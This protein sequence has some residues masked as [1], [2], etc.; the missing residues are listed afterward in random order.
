LIIGT[1]GHID[2]GKTSLVKALTGVDTDRLKEEKARGITI[3]LGFAYAPLP[4]GGT[5]AFV[6]VPGHEKLIRNMLAGATG[7]DGVL[8]VVAAD[9][10]P[11]PQTREHL[12]IL[13]LLG[14]DRG[15]V[16][17]TKADLVEPARVDAVAA[18]MRTL[19]DGTALAAAPLVPVSSVTGAGI[20]ELRHRLQQAATAAPRRESQGRF[21]LAVDRCFTL[22]GHGTVVTGTAAAGRV[23]V[24]DR[25]VV[26]PRGLAVRVR[27]LHAGNRAAEHGGAGERCALNLAGTGLQKSDVERG[28]W[29]VAEPAHA[30]TDRL[31]ARLLLLGGEAKPLVHWTPLRLHL[32]AAEVGARVVPLQ[33]AGVAPGAAALVQLELDRPIGAL[34]GD[35]FI[36]RDQSA[37]RTLGGGRVIDPFAAARGR[38]RPQRLAQLQA[39]EAPTAAESL[40]A[41]LALAPVD[42]VDLTAFATL[43][44]LDDAERAALLQAVPHTALGDGATQLAFAPAQLERFSAALVAALNQHHRKAPD[45]PGLMLEPLRRSIELK[46]RADVFALLLQHAVGAGRVTRHGPYLSLPGHEVSLLAAEQKLWERV[47]PWLLEAGMHPPRLSDLAARDRSIKPDQLQRLLR[48]L[49]R[50]GRLYAVGNDY[51]VLPQHMRQ[52][53]QQSKALAEADPQR[54]LNVKAL[55]ETTGMSRHLSVPLVEF[56]DHIGFT[57]RAKDGRHVKRD[58][59]AVFG[60]GGAGGTA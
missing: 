47:H 14:L 6:D 50:M 12:A 21:R 56:F 8:L 46:P 59:A 34:R 37:Q 49:A 7:I 15:V 9:D 41:L 26:S 28:D 16:A 31:D 18:Q 30:P 27:G 24:G 20:D 54:R 42:G 60:A 53:A 40:A 5:L 51:Y 33:G 43:W 19:L 13:D 1:A 3:D 58:V 23:A 25:L 35:R 55:R 17:L 10:G 11:M 4:D 52:L 44:N 38:R 48:K 57:K 22:A 45:S 32:G 36:V 29:I 2:H 39:L